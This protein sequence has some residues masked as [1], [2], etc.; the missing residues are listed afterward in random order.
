M[1]LL[2]RAGKPPWLLGVAVVTLQLL[3]DVPQPGQVL[4]CLLA[5][6]SPP[7]LSLLLGKT[8]NILD[9]GAIAKTPN[10]DATTSLFQLLILDPLLSLIPHGV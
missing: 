8:V 4:G 10:L 1:R 9:E 3:L 5:V 6:L 7:P 2:G